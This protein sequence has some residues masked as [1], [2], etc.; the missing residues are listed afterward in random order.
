MGKKATKKT[1]IVDIAKKQRHL[2]LLGKVKQGKVL[3]LKEI[4]ELEYRERQRK[5]KDAKS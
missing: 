5:E 2:Y 3:T 1:D 4:G